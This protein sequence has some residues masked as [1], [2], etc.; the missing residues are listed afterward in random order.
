MAEE[1]SFNRKSAKD[2]KT[3]S[4]IMIDGIPCKIVDVETSQPGKHGSAK[5]RITGI[6]IFDGQKK[7]LL[8]P[9]HGDVEV[10]DIRKRRAQVVSLSG[11]TV[12]LMDM[13]TYEVYDAVIPEELRSTLKPGNE[14][15][16]LEA[17]GRRLITRIMGGF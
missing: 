14:V 6:G 13:E 12:Q 4:F 9:S 11:S 7:T 5:M 1:H 16:V 10:P 17:M 8:T 15:E 2:V 3:G